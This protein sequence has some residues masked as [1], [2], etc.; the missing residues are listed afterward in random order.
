LDLANQPSGKDVSGVPPGKVEVSPETPSREGFSTIPTTNKVKET[1]LELLRLPETEGF[2]DHS[3]NEGLL[4]ALGGY[5][6]YPMTGGRVF[7]Y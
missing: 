2:L 4:K 7:K 5:Y 1:L 6:G 3:H